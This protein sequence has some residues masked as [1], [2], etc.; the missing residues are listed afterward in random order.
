ML[1]PARLLA[2]PLLLLLLPAANA[3][4]INIPITV[5]RA[6][7]ERA[8]Q[9][10][11]PQNARSRQQVDHRSTQPN[12]PGSRERRGSSQTSHLGRASDNHLSGSESPSGNSTTR[13]GTRKKSGK[14]NGQAKKRTKKRSYK[15]PA[16]RRLAEAR[17]TLE[18]ARAAFDETSRERQTADERR[19]TQQNDRDDAA[20]RVRDLKTE[21]DAAVETYVTVDKQIPGLEQSLL[22][23]IGLAEQAGKAVEMLQAKRKGFERSVLDWFRFSSKNNLREK[24]GAYASALERQERAAQTLQAAEQRLEAAAVAYETAE[25]Q[26]PEAQKALKASEAALARA[27]TELQEATDN[28]ARIEGIVN[29]WEHEVSSRQVKAD[30]RNRRYD[31]RFARFNQ[32]LLRIFP[33]ARRRAVYRKAVKRMKVVSFNEPKP[34]QI[35][36]DAVAFAPEDG[37]FAIADGVT[38]SVLP[39]AFARALVRG[40]MER[41][42]SDYEG[43]EK[44]L[45]TAQSEWLEENA[46]QIAELRKEYPEDLYDIVGAATFVGAKLGPKKDGKYKMKLV[47][48]G[49]AVAFL[50]R[51]GKRIASFPQRAANEFT[52]ESGGLRTD[53]E[54]DDENVLPDDVTWTAKPGDEVYLVTDALGKWIQTELEAKRTPFRTLRKIQ[55]QKA[56]STFVAERREGATA[57]RVKKAKNAPAD[58]EIDDTTMLRFVVP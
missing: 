26:K 5:V 9:R 19:A 18:Q 55:D 25:A 53:H 35:S 42:F 49:D 57:G 16:E 56:M 38:N 29:G 34:D 40:W 3:A 54:M 11:D 24:V 15:T 23:E 47:G 6:V 46:D 17:E 7:E 50:V 21:A 52:D 10:A 33:S 36:Q 45:E 8:A 2:L 41:P 43:F 32:H 48:K 58:M 31:E 30:E 39:D 28:L 27:E 4:A 1:P 20:R 51:N 44:W 22:E 14:N 12:S 13:Q 37:L